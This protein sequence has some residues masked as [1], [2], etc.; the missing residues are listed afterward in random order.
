MDYKFL[1]V[2]K[3]ANPHA[4]VAQL[5]TDDLRRGPD[6][7]VTGKQRIGK[8]GNPKCPM[9]IS[10]LKKDIGIYKY[11]DDGP[12]R[13]VEGVDRQ[14]S[15][16]KAVLIATAQVTRVAFYRP[17]KNVGEVRL[18]DDPPNDLGQLNGEQPI[19]CGLAPLVDIP[20]TDYKMAVNVASDCDSESDKI[21]FYAIPK[22]AGK[23]EIKRYTKRVVNAKTLAAAAE[24]MTSQ[25]PSGTQPDADVEEGKVVV[26]EQDID[27]EASTAPGTPEPTPRGGKRIKRKSSPQA[28][29]E[30][31]RIKNR[32]RIVYVGPKGGRYIKSKGEYKRI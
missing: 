10:S 23:D 13:S 29:S 32:E 30:R 4:L 17:S 27:D 3:H 22:S 21:L 6:S 31:V 5:A 19:K 25:F 16:V 7:G 9:D 20:G 15:D 2:Y 12:G 14:V 28:T 11:V 18:V 8:K 24:V 26:S 1:H